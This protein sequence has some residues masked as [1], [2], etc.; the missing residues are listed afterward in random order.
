MRASMVLL[1][2]M[3]ACNNSDPEA[4]VADPVLLQA[5]GGAMLANPDVHTQLPVRVAVDGTVDSVRVRGPGGDAEGLLEEDGVYVAWLATGTQS[6]TVDV[7]VQGPD[8]ERSTSAELVLSTE[9]IQLTTLEAAGATTTPGLVWS[10]GVLWGTWCD[11]SE[12][13]SQC[14]A[15]ELDGAGRWQ[16]ERVSIVPTTEDVLYARTA[17]IDGYL[18]VLYQLPVGSPYLNRVRVVDFSGGVV[19]DSIDLHEPGW[20]GTFGGDVDAD[21]DGFALTWR[22]RSTTT[23]DGRVRWMRVGVDGTTVGP[24]T[25]AASGDGLPVGNFGPFSFVEIAVHDGASLVTWTQDEYSADLGLQVPKAQFAVIDADG[26]VIETGYLGDRTGYDWDNEAH[27]GVAK[28]ELMALWSLDDLTSLDDV[29]PTEIAARTFSPTGDPVRLGASI[30]KAPNTRGEPV[31]FDHPGHSAAVAWID[32]RTYS[33][34]DQG[35]VQLHVASLSENLQARPALIYSHAQF[36]SGL[37][38]LGGV[39][40]DHNVLL[41]WRDQRNGGTYSEM[42]FETAWIAP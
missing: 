15:Q 12:A 3:M 31:L 17:A 11:K 21:A 27:A 19:V 42:W 33:E 16:G 30:E 37:T 41:T 18:A 4:S 9:G 1:I 36:F 28:G 32:H 20:E 5:V 26:G 25:V 35:Q 13:L 14:W 22:E 23:S 40:A 24:V 38:D 8:G 6:G 7:S 2:A 10:E 34:E 29:I 39:M